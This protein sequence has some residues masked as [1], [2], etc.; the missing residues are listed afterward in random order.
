MTLHAVATCSCHVFKT[1]PF[2]VYLYS[3]PCHSTICDID[4]CDLTVFVAKSSRLFL[5][6]KHGVRWLGGPIQRGQFICQE[7]VSLGISSSEY[8]LEY[9]FFLFTGSNR[10][11]NILYFATNLWDLLN[12][13]LFKIRLC[14][15]SCSTSRLDSDF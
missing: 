5:I 15:P 14:F 2:S 6:F 7:C 9:L 11:I 10:S 4:A 3:V 8:S 13:I 1:S 12:C